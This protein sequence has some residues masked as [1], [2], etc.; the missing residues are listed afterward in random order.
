MRQSPGQFVV[1][2]SGSHSASPQ[3]GVQSTAPVSFASPRLTEHTPSPHNGSGSG[4]DFGH[5]DPSP[6]SPASNWNQIESTKW[7]RSR[8]RVQPLSSNAAPKGGHGREREHAA[9]VQLAGRRRG[10]AVIDVDDLD[11]ALGPVVEQQTSF[12]IDQRSVRITM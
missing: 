2:S 10:D 7:V 1:P 11:E 6:L 8:T 3:V 12:G 9:E 4:G 5:T